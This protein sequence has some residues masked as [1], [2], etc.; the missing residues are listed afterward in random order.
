MIDLNSLSQIIYPMSQEISGGEAGD[1][2]ESSGISE[3][4]A[5]SLLPPPADTF[6]SG[7]SNWSGRL[8][9]TQTHGS[10]SKPKSVTFGNVP[11]SSSGIGSVSGTEERRSDESYNPSNIHSVSECPSLG[12]D[13]DSVVRRSQRTSIPLTRYIASEGSSSKTHSHGQG[14]S[15]GEANFAVLLFAS[16]KE[17]NTFGEAMRFPE[18]EKWQK[19]MDDEMNS[20][21]EKGTWKLVE[22]PENRKPLKNK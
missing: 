16:A 19:A 20:L 11:I 22:L 3:A 8:P 21:R 7:S 10:S 14:D 9:L 15:D 2:N 18:K 17:S 13:T 5:D 12:S 4:V 1:V 6:S